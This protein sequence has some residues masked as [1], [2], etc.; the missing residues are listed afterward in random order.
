MY[1]TEIPMP[2]ESITPE[3]ERRAAEREAGRL[4]QTRRKITYRCTECGREMTREQLRAKRVQYR[5]L[6]GDRRVVRPRTVAWLC[7]SPP[8]GGKSCL[9]LD[10]DWHRQS[11]RDAPGFQ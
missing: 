4:A 11:L 8:R 7:V 2:P 6:V 5:E 1:V 9:D 3:D 10:A